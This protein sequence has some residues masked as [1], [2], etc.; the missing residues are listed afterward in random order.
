MSYETLNQVAENLYRKTTGRAEGRYMARIKR[1]GRI[2]ERTFDTTD[3]AIAK[4]MLRDFEKEVEG[5]TAVSSDMTFEQLCERWKDSVRAGLKPSAFKRRLCSINAITP[6]FARLS[7]RRINKEQAQEWSE[8]REEMS[9]STY[10]NEYDTI[11]ALFEFAR[12]HNM[13]GGKNPI[14]GIPKKTMEKTVVIPPTKEEFQTL[15]EHLAL[16]PKAKESMFL[17]QLLAYSGM[18]VN[19]ARHVQWRHVNF[20]RG[21][22]LI[23]SGADMNKNMEQREIPLFPALRDLLLEK[24]ADSP[25]DYLLEIGSARTALISASE[26]MGIPEGEHFTHHKMRHFFASNAL[27]NPQVT[28]QMLGGWLG[29]KDGGVLAAKRYGHLRKSHSDEVAKVMT[30]SYKPTAQPA[31]VDTSKETVQWIQA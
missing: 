29:H 9:A 18:R 19:E 12:T 10:I 2:H 11:S 5:K 14:E 25:R 28:F 15:M 27:E 23:T 26:K 13:Y 4:R 21:K 16:E 17:V 3:L 20:E 22:F 8:N 30:F 6:Y 1:G 24:G 7:L 31:N